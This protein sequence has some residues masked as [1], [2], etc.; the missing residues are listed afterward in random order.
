M[1]ISITTQKNSCFLFSKIGVA[2][3]GVSTVPNMDNIHNS[4]VTEFKIINYQECGL[5]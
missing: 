5:L 4:N 1:Q 2:N 3:R